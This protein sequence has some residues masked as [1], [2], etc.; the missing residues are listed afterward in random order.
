M[1]LSPAPSALPPTGPMVPGQA[2]MLPTAPMMLQQ[3]DLIGQAATTRVQYMNAMMQRPGVLQTI[4]GQGINLLKTIA[5]IGGFLLLT[6]VGIKTI[7]GQP[8]KFLSGQ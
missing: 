2:P 8:P 3:P 1:P 5:P 4:A 6:W 7:L